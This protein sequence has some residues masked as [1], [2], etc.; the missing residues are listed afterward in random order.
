M[1]SGFDARYEPR[2][3]YVEVYQKLY[4]KYQNLGKYTE[5]DK[6]FSQSK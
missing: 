5:N 1:G 6:I 2:A 3:D 4:G